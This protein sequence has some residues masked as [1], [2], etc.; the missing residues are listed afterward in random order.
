M[1]GLF[2]GW[3]YP[4][5]LAA[6][7][8]IA[9]L[10]GGGTYLVGRALGSGADHHPRL[11]KVLESRGFHRA[12]DALNRWGPPMVSLCFLTFGFQTLVNLSAGVTK[13]P[14]KR[15][16]P[17]LAVGALLWG[18]LYATVGFVT[19]VA[20]YRVYQRWPIVALVILV[21]VVGGIIAFVATQVLGLR[22]GQS[23]AGPTAGNDDESTVTQGPSATDG[24]SAAGRDVDH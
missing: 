9:F 4:L 17:A 8:L 6:L 1:N 24:R 7:S 2:S 14:P 15:Y 23:Q 10:R 12:S 13:M 16:V 3:P 11:H 21:L 20:W 18:F 19:V 22:R 5:A